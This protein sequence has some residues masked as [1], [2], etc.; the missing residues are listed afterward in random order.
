M[1]VANL[2]L[3]RFLK[4]REKDAHVRDKT[5]IHRKLYP[6]QRRRWRFADWIK[7]NCLHDGYLKLVSSRFGGDISQNLH[8]EISALCDIEDNSK[9]GIKGLIKMA[10]ASFTET[11]CIRLCGLLKLHRARE[12]GVLVLGVKISS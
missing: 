11:T 10:N 2:Y 8:I 4:S 3:K 5:S 1:K 6:G 12:L 7:M 9:R